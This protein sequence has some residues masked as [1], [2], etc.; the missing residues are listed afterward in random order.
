M[1]LRDFF[2]NSTVLPESPIERVLRSQL[3]LSSQWR[4]VGAKVESD[5]KPY[6]DTYPGVKEAVRSRDLVPS[7]CGTVRYWISQERADTYRC[8]RC[9]NHAKPISYRTRELKHNVD[10]G[11]RCILYVNIPKLKCDRCG[12]TPSVRFPAAD[13]RKGY[14]RR[15]A[16]AVL[17]ALKTR[18]KTDVARE[19]GLDWGTVDMILD[20]AIREAIPEQD[21]SYVTG[22][23]VDETQFGSGQSYI[24]TFLDQKHKVIFVCEGHGKDV[25]K[26]FE[27]HLIVQGG[28]PESIRFFS[29]DMSK[30]YEAGIIE[31]FPNAELVWDRFHLAKA[32]NEAV[33]DIRKK[34]VKRDEG[35]TLR[36][37]KYTVLSR[38]R[39]H[40]QG[41]T[42]RLR[43]IRLNNPEMALA[44]DM[45]EV[46]LDIIKI[47]DP[48]SMRRCL[49]AWIDWVE[50]EGH[51]KLKKKAAGFREKMDRIMAWT[52]YPVSNSVAE[53]VNKNI[54]DARRQA[55]GFSNF[56]SFF[57]TVMLR[58]GDL[59]YRF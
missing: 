13:E 54:Q 29:A 51:E 41:H 39:N 56:R 59:T 50:L 31:T 47:P 49:L 42:E 15:L 46:F 22:V 1:A 53:G 16:K 11:F 58:Q 30:A 20:D 6:S 36:L 4:V 48:K 14:T 12:G 25:L 9:G 32:V 38:R 57:N 19:F 44:F 33:N 37:V 23:Y 45:K 2:V 8:P 52:S 5:Q 34:L 43:K 35:E 21:L 24:S 40:T 26:L 55:C 17:A 18:S 3:G 27:S 7:C 10:K 28:D